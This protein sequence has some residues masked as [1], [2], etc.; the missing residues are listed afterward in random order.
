MHSTE[1]NTDGITF[2]HNGDY[3]GELWI[4]ID[5]TADWEY[6]HGP[7]VEYKK[8]NDEFGFPGHWTVKI[9]FDDIKGVVA[10]YVRSLKVEALEDAEPDEILGA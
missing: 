10:D 6:K 7:A 9:P 1:G 2:H 5:D 4:T 3:S 8:P